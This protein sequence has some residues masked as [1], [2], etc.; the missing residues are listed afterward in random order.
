VAVVQ[1]TFTHKHNTEYREQNIHNNQK[2]GTYKQSTNLKL[3]WE[4]QAMP[5]LYELYP[6]IC[7]TNEEKSW[8]NLSPSASA[9]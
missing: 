9:Y 8:K 6:G 5:R 7:L 1:S 3:I 2:I 4:V